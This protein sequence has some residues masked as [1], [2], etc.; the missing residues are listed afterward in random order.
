MTEY[1]FKDGC[2]WDGGDWK[3]VTNYECSKLFGG[4]P[5]KHC[6][7]ERDIQTE[8]V[9]GGTFTERVWI[10]PSVITAENEGGHNS[11]GVCLQCVLEASRQIDLE[12][13]TA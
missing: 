6:H 5:C 1:V 11:T 13:L 7:D 3:I 4:L 8:D 2:M 12:I 10:C 9:L